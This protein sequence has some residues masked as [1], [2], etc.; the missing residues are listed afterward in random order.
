MR[1]RR[2]DRRVRPAAAMRAVAAGA[3]ACLLSGC[4]LLGASTS[5][6]QNDPL[7]MTVTSPE[8]GVHTPIPADYTCHDAAESP[9]LDWSGAPA[10]TR[11]LAVVMDDSATPIS[12]YAYWIVFN[13]STQTPEIL[14][15]RIP[16]G[17]LEA[18]NSKGTIGYDPP[19]PSG[20]H[21]YR[22]TVYALNA[23]L[24]LPAGASLTAAWSA[25]ATHAVGYGRLTAEVIPRGDSPG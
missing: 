10:S 25:I 17:A 4:G 21:T 13:I 14:P 1:L 6:Q 15:G 2:C 20:A 5:T 24:Q 11:A 12:P 18:R 3:A 22:F 7:V 9:P 19:C 23:P 16:P 8:F